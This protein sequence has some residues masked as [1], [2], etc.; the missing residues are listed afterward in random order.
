MSM[1]GYFYQTDDITV[2]K[3]REGADTEFMFE[4]ENEGNMLCIDKAW[5]AI[6]FTLTG[7]EWEVSEDKPISQ[8]VLGGEPVNDEDMG[9]G[10]MRLIPR[11]LVSQIADALAEVDQAVFQSKF[12]LKDMM[13]KQ[14]Y[15]VMY[16]ENEKQFFSYVWEMFVELKKFYKDAS[17]KNHNVLTFIA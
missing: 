9:Y 16:N 6:H 7:E 11:E 13:E 2:Q 12:N 15:P 17:E 3:L 10:P 14:I 8:A 5:H 4:E 1:I